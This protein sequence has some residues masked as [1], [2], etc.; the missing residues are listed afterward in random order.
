MSSLDRCAAARHHVRNRGEIFDG[1]LDAE[2]AVQLLQ[3]RWFAVLAATRSVQAECD[4]LFEA[5]MLADAAWRR[6]DAQRTGF[7]ALR[8]ALELEMCAMEGARAERRDFERLTAI[9][10]A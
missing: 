3:R 6:A 5:L 1:D 8:D 4:L 2:P 9:S 10:A 7:V